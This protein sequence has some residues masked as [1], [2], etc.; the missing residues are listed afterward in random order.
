MIHC[1][2]CVAG[3]VWVSAGVLVTCRSLVLDVEVGGRMGPLADCDSFTDGAAPR[4]LAD[5]S[6]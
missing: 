6:C 3:R 2:T 4:R 5:L 1:L